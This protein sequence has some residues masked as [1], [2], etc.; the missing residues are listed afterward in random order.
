MSHLTK[1]KFRAKCL[2]TLEAA[3]PKVDLVLVRDQKTHKWYGTFLNDSGPTGR[4]ANRNQ[5][6]GRCD[7][8]LRHKDHKPG[9]YEIGVVAEPDGSFAFYHDDFGSSGRRL[10]AA[11]GADYGRLTQEYAVAATERRV[12]KTLAREG[13]RAERENLPNGNVRLRLRRR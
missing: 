10:T 9:D 12:A 6:N 8:V 1:G 2:D 5:A 11:V 13:F 3:A 4:A 7:H